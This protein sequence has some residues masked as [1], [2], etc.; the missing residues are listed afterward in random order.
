MPSVASLRKA[1]GRHRP[2]ARSD[3]FFGSFFSTGRGFSSSSS[4][5]RSRTRSA[6]F[7]SARSLATN[8]AHS[9]LVAGA[10]RAYLM[11][12]RWMI[13][14]LVG[15]LVEQADHLGCQVPPLPLAQVLDG[16]VDDVRLGEQW[17][18]GGHDVRLLEHF[19]PVLP[20]EPQRPQGR[21]PDQEVRLRVLDDPGQVLPARPSGRAGRTRPTARRARSPGGRSGSSI[22]AR[23]AL[24]VGLP[25]AAV[26][27]DQPQEPEPGLE[28][29]GSL[30]ILR[31]CSGSNLAAATRTSLYSALVNSWK[32]SPD[33]AQSG[34][35]KYLKK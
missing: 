1:S 16:E 4:C 24:A 20:E 15:R 33:T 18:D 25:L 13:E 14:R 10:D 30:S 12:L 23:R 9:W 5:S 26:A 8:S 17:L 2:A 35:S 7:S 21:V 6:C 34:E 32:A 3:Y 19:L 28:V 22:I 11:M 27:E 31:T 29:F